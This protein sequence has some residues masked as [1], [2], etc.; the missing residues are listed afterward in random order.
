MGKWRK[1]DLTR[2]FERPALGQLTAL[3]LVDKRERLYTKEAYDIGRF[4]T[5]P[6][7]PGSRKLWWRDGNGGFDPVRM[8]KH[9][10]IWW[11]PVPEFDG[12]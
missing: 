3:R 10:E 11:C 6:R 7:A 9:Y 2:T 1:L 12:V 4:E 8:K 5:D